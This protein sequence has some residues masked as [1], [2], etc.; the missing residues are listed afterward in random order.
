MWYFMLKSGIHPTITGVLLAFAIPF[1]KGDE[2]SPSYILQHYL[3]KPVAYIVLPV[4][5]LANTAIALSSNWL[6]SFSEPYSLG[7]LTGLAIGKPL[8]ITLFSF[9]AVSL[10]LAFLPEDVSWKHIIGTGFLA[11]IG[12]TMSIFIT[13]LAFNN[14]III[15][16]AKAVIIVA[17]VISGLTGF[18]ILRLVMKI[19]SK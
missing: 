19:K 10:G 2:H 11:G 3:H 5:A 6:E 18:L 8:G 12:F 16:N 13:L 4:F 17:S 9:I 15:N 1:A 14:A 7:I